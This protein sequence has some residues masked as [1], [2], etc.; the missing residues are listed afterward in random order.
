[1]LVMMSQQKHVAY[2]EMNQLSDILGQQWT[3]HRPV[4]NVHRCSVNDVC[5]DGHC[6][7]TH[8]KR[9]SNHDYTVRTQSKKSQVQGS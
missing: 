2:K 5:L 7:L 3:T 1:M 6:V 8:T 9:L 4:H